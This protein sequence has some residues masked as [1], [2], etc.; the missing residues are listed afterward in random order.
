LEDDR[1]NGG[2]L[3]SDA[4]LKQLYTTMLQCRLLTERA[5]RAHN[6]NGSASLYAASMGQEAIAT[7]CAIDLRP[8]DTI[9][10][11]ESVTSR[12]IAGLVKGVP[13]NAIVAELYANDQPSHPPSPI[14]AQLSAA[15]GLAL[16]NKREK[17]TAVWSLLPARQSPHSAPGMRRSHSPLAA[18]CP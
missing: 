15:T 8:E 1:S 7:G 4:K 10:S 3:I 18:A 2:S 12:I 11:H 9:A 5:R 6:R 14:E 13:L 16:A 17:N